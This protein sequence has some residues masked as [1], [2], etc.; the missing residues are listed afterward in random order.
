MADPRV[1]VVGAGPAGVRAA[2]TLVAAGM[3]PTVVDENARWG[4]QIYRQPP[5][6]GGFQRSKKT[7]YGF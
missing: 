5:E 2:E 4:G 1:I 6:H 7:L 3:R